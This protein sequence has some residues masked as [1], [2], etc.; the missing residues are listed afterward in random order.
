M[1]VAGLLS[2]LGDALLRKKNRVANDYEAC[3]HLTMIWCFDR[4]LKKKETCGLYLLMRIKE[5]LKLM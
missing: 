4:S 3:E 5:G 2:S 1:V